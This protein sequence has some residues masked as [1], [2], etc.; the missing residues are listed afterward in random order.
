MVPAKHIKL[1]V[2]DL[3][4]VLFDKY[5]NYVNGEIVKMNSWDL[6]FYE[7]GAWEENLYLMKLWKDGILPD[8]FTWNEEACK[9]W[10]DR[11]LKRNKFEEIVKKMPLRKE[12]KETVEELKKRGYKTATVTGSPEALASR[13]E[14]ELGLDYAIGHC[15]LYFDKEGK[16]KDWDLFPTDFEDKVECVKKIAKRERISLMEC[17]Y[18]GDG[19]NDIYVM[20]EVGIPIAFRAESEKVRNVA[21]YVIKD[22]R[23]LLDLFPKK[24]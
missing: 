15:R 19:E 9:V 5:E 2:F 24:I 6:I 1:V 16:L 4:N 14:K 18:V 17:A 22:L 23:E 10:K 3:E 20:S 13:A 12:A 11:N 8:Y 21:R 7:L